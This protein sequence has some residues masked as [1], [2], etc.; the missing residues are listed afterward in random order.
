M[1]KVKEKIKKKTKKI[2]PP[3]VVPGGY[4]IDGEFIHEIT[5]PPAELAQEA[6]NS[7]STARPFVD[8][9]STLLRVL[10]QESYDLI[11]ARLATIIDR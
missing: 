10:T 9:G 4:I 2:A 1:A 3:N 7:L 5:G 8:S 6:L 11:E